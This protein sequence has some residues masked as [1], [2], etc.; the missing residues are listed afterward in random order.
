MEDS[1][2]YQQLFGILIWACELVWI[3]VFTEVIVLS[4]HL[5]NPIEGH[6]DAV[7]HIFN[8]LN[9]K[10][11]CIPVKL[12]FDDL[13]Q[14]PCICPIK[15]ASTEKNDFMDF[16]PDAEDILPNWMPDPLVSKV[17]ICVCVDANHA[18]NLP[19]RSLYSVIII[20]V[21]NA[22]I[23]CYIRRYNMV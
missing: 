18:V 17:I 14:P 22:P 20:C 1:N 5:Y 21:N 3:D 15:V 12:V 13:Y 23:L 11:K 4:Q 9:V 16:Y 10:R 19:N 2:T 7:F 6:L 8:Y